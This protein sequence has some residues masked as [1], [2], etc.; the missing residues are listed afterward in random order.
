MPE[1][2]RIATEAALATVDLRR[3]GTIGIALNGVKARV[4]SPSRITLRTHDHRHGLHFDAGG[5]EELSDL[6]GVLNDV[7]RDAAHN[8][9]E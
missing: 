9:S 6:G 2:E 3:F 4:A 8:H 1:P 5:G 7:Q